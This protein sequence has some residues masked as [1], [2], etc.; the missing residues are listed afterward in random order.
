MGGEAR[1][2]KR[3]VDVDQR[4]LQRQSKRR[5]IDVIDIAGLRRQFEIVDF[6]AE[7]ES[8]RRR[9]IQ[10]NQ[11]LGK[12]TELTLEGIG[13]EPSSATTRTCALL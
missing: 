11:P 12:A 7:R 1:R 3:R 13:R 6:R 10:R 2:V 5:S 9:G 8:R 4:L